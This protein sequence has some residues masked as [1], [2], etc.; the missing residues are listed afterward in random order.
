M[1]PVRIIYFDPS[2]DNS[3]VNLTPFVPTDAAP[4]DFVI[5]AER[6]RDG[7]IGS[8]IILGWPVPP[9]RKGPTILGEVS[10]P[11]AIQDPAALALAPLLV[12]VI[13]RLDKIEARL[14]PSEH[15]EPDDP[16]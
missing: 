2:P 15:V 9:P 14:S 7:R 10:K 11:V 13:R 16:S 4:G 6:R 8:T 3:P 1:N 12:D 5:L